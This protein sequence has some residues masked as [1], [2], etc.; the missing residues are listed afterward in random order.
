MISELLIPQW[1][2]SSRSKPGHS[3]LTQMTHR[4]C[5][6]YNKTQYL[7]F[8]LGMYCRKTRLPLQST[9][10]SSINFIFAVRTRLGD[11]SWDVPLSSSAYTI[12]TSLRCSIIRKMPTAMVGL[13]TSQIRNFL[14]SESSVNSQ[15]RIL[16]F[17]FRFSDEINCSAMRLTSVVIN[18]TI[19]TRVLNCL[20]GGVGVWAESPTLAVSDTMINYIIWWFI[21]VF[22]IYPN[23]WHINW[24]CQDVDV[25][26]RFY[27]I[28]VF[29]VSNGSID[30]MST[31]LSTCPWTWYY[32]FLCHIMCQLRLASNHDHYLNCQNPTA[33][34]RH[35]YVINFYS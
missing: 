26:F 33:I 5:T 29:I 17:D 4:S 12:H 25:T 14:I 9:L 13:S 8:L 7:C 3:R 27:T 16:L 11:Y 18:S 24:W 20:M 10:D 32:I 21:D 15:A 19:A 23:T 31:S 35:Q 1:N 34:L 6:Q 28:N 30:N 2:P 22:H